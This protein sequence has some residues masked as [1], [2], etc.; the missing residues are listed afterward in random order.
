MTLP[1]SRIPHVE[2]ALAWIETNVPV[3][4]V[5]AMCPDSPQHSTPPE[6]LMAQ[7]WYLPDVTA[8]Y[9]PVGV[10]DT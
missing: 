1:E 10:L 8:V 3:L 2:L 5:E 7:L 4:G 9:V 6:V